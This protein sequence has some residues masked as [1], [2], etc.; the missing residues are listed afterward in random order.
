M[1]HNCRTGVAWESASVGKSV[2]M[3]VSREAMAV[4]PDFKETVLGP[5]LDDLRRPN[6][7]T[8]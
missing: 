1:S 7:G 4:L 2:R 6:A 8:P 5:F 3:V